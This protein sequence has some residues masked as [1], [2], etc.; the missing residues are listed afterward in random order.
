MAG[1]YIH[2]PFCKTRCIYCDFYS[3]TDHRWQTRYVAALCRELTDRVPYLQGQTVDTIYI[4]GGTPS[5]LPVVPDLYDIF[6]TIKGEYN[7]SP[8][9]EI[10]LEA[11]P[12][13]LTP[14]YVE[15]LRHLPINRLS[16][17]IQTFDD[18]MLHLLSR[19]HTAVQAIRAFERCRE[20]G[21]DNI[22]IDL[23]YGLPGQTDEQWLYDLQQATLLD[24]E[25]ISAYHLTIEK[26]TP[27]S[28]MTELK[29]VDE[30]TSVRFFDMLVDTLQAAGYEHYE[31]SNFCK[32][33]RR[34]R[35]N[36]AYWQGIAY[37]GVGA[38]A[39]SFDGTS[40]QWNVAA[41]KK[42]IEGIE[43]GHPHYEVEQLTLSARYN[44][45]I[46]TGL[47]TRHGISLFEIEAKFGLPFYHYCAGRMERYLQTG[48]LEQ[49]GDRI[50]LSRRGVFVSDGIISDLMHVG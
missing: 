42:Y 7:V 18:R 33:G 50:R 32:P 48:L 35:H 30:E 12:D 10:T 24:P 14:K 21:F 47:R 17:G 39:H 27:L 16:I 6:S 49:S 40:R 4:G 3:S 46:M 9:A 2:I 38:S 22:S 37:L 8:D 25:H 29:T 1:I 26:G 19:R 41:L 36:S 15:L 34:S 13:D 31:I 28:R 43:T 11:N 45:Y 5:Q 23:M 20:A 44:E